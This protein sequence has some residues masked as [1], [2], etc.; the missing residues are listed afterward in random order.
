MII[1]DKHGFAN[2]KVLQIFPLCL[3][4]EGGMQQ[5]CAAFNPSSLIK[6]ENLKFYDLK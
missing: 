4:L 1:K 6:I 3:N 5:I 2:I